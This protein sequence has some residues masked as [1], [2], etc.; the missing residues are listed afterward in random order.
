MANGLFPACYQW[1]T[2]DGLDE[3]RKNVAAGSS[4]LRSTTAGLEYSLTLAVVR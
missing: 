4:F 3:A 2:W 1:V